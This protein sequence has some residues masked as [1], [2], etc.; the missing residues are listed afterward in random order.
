VDERVDGEREEQWEIAG[1]TNIGEGESFTIWR[2]SKAEKE[3][4]KNR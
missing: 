3:R 1:E 4:E 2:R